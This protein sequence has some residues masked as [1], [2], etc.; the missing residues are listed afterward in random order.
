MTVKFCF[1]LLFSKRTH[2]AS[3]APECGIKGHRAGGRRGREREGLEQPTFAKWSGTISVHN[4]RGYYYYYFVVVGVGA[5]RSTDG[6]SQFH[7]NRTKLWVIWVDGCDDYISSFYYKLYLCAE[8]CWKES[9]RE[10]G[11][12][13]GLGNVILITKRGYLLYFAN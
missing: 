12:V 1:F 3:G 6:V 9:K 5:E 4:E 11:G 8:R 10:Y 7:F 13:L 2:N